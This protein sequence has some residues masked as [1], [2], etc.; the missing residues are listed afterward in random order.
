MCVC[1]RL[2]VLSRSLC[3]AVSSLLRCR[4]E[5]DAGQTG[6]DNGS[7]VGAVAHPIGQRPGPTRGRGDRGL[8]GSHSSGSVMMVICARSQRF[9]TKPPSVLVR[10]RKTGHGALAAAAAAARLA[11]TAVNV[12]PRCCHDRCV[13]RVQPTHRFM[14]HGTT[15]INTHPMP[16]VPQHYWP[17]LERGVLPSESA[18]PDDAA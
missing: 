3:E 7:Q 2:W 6:D 5:Q 11:H 16:A 17:Y 18:Q 8:D 10:A 4:S 13:F 1:V 12:R 14:A 15:R 9:V